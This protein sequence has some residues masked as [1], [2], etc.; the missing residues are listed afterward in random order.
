MDDDTGARA[1]PELWIDW[2]D[3]IVSFHQEDGYERL[4]FSSDEEKMNYVL[5]KSSAGF[6]VQ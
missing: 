5:Q 6:R 4:E 2:T 1:L 3:H